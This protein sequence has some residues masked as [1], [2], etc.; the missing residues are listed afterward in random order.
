MGGFS[1]CKLQELSLALHSDSASI[2]AAYGTL[3][4]IDLKLLFM[5]AV[6]QAQHDD[7]CCA[8]DTETVRDHHRAQSMEPSSFRSAGPRP[9]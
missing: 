1:F 3:A 9:I 4:A 7:Y 5:E 6:W 8:D 2:P